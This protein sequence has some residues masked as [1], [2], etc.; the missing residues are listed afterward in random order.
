MTNDPPNSQNNPTPQQTDGCDK[1]NNMFPKGP[2]ENIDHTRLIDGR[3][4]WSVAVLLHKQ[5][6]VL[7]C[8]R[9]VSALGLCHTHECE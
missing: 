7:M 5:F 6:H 4:F 9:V 2:I 3:C 8:A 1:T